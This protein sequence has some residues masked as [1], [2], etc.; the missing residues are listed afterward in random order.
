MAYA[1][2][3]FKEKYDNFIGGEWVTPIDDEDGCILIDDTILN[4]L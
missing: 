2:P 3:N 1:R 4:K